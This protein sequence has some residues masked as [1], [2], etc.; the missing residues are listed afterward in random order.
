MQAEIESCQDEED[1]PTKRKPK[2]EKKQHILSETEDINEKWISEH[3]RQ[4]QDVMNHHNMKS[5]FSIN[6]VFIT[7]YKLLF[8]LRLTECF[9]EAFI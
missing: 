4:V 8:Y 5:S 6:M 3:A 7:N 1:M 2:K 9:Q